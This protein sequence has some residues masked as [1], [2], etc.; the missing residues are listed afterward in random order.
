[1]FLLLAVVAWRRWG[2]SVV[3]NLLWRLCTFGRVV[4]LF[5]LDIQHCLSVVCSYYRFMEFILVPI[6]IV[7][8]C[9]C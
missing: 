1:M 7:V 3:F 6:I 9:S 2:L 8:S 4:V 5:L